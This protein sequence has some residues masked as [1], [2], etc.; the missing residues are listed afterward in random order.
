MSQGLAVCI[1]LYWECESHYVDFTDKQQKI[2]VR[3]LKEGEEGERETRVEITLQVKQYK[4][5][6]PYG[7]LSCNL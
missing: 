5:G 2:K 7:E 3:E 1:A 4:P 6:V